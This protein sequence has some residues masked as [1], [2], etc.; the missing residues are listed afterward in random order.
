MSECGWGVVRKAS[1]QGWGCQ[2]SESDPH[3][4]RED[5]G[6]GKPLPRVLASLMM[7]QMVEGAPFW[8][9]PR[10]QMEL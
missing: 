7:V 6:E 5:E 10:I 8:R 3:C 9:S 2:G 4:P 1:P